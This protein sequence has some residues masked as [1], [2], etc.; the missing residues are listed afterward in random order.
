MKA[1]KPGTDQRVEFYVLVD[2]E[3]VQEYTLPSAD[4]QP[5][6]NTIER[7]IAVKPNQDI[8]VKGLF[9]GTCL[10]SSYDLVVDGSFLT[11]RRVSGNNSGQLIV[12]RRDIDLDDPMDCPL[13]KGWK[14]MKSPTDLYQGKLF[15]Q[16]LSST[17]VN[18]IGK[19]EQ[20][21]QGAAR[22]GVG[23][24][25][26][27]VS[28]NQQGQDQYVDKEWD[29][30]LQG[31][32]NRGQVHVRPSGVTPDHT[33]G[34]HRSKKVGQKQSKRHRDHFEGTR[35]GSGPWARFVFYYRS[36]EALE[37][38]G[39]VPAP[40]EQLALEPHN[41]DFYFAPPMRAK[42]K[43]G[44][45]EAEGKEHP[46]RGQPKGAS[47]T[48]APSARSDASDEEDAEEEDAAVEEG[49]V[50][51]KKSNMRTRSMRDSAS[52]DSDDDMQDDKEI[53][54]SIDAE[55]QPQRVVSSPSR[56]TIAGFSGAPWAFGRPQEA[57]CSSDPVNDSIGSWSFD[58]LDKT[59]VPQSPAQAVPDR[60]QD[61]HEQQVGLTSEPDRRSDSDET[62]G[63][64]TP[65]LSAKR[66]A[67][68]ALSKILGTGLVDDSTRSSAKGKKSG[69]KSSIA[70]QAAATRKASAS[71]FG[72]RNLNSGSST[73]AK[74]EPRAKMDWSCLPSEK[75]IVAFIGEGGRATDSLMSIFPKGEWVDDHLVGN[76]DRAHL[77]KK[78]AK[79]ELYRRV[80]L[81]AEKDPNNETW[82]WLKPEYRQQG[83]GEQVSCP[84]AS[85][86]AVQNDRNEEVGDSNSTTAPSAAATPTPNH[87]RGPSSSMT[88]DTAT[89]KKARTMTP[90]EQLIEATQKL[91]QREAEVAEMKAKLER[92]KA[93]KAQQDEAA[94]RAK[95]AAALREVERV[96][97]D[98]SALE[99]EQAEI[100]AQLAA[101]EGV[102]SDGEEE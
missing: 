78:Q 90:S 1:Q 91:A 10:H 100:A 80:L 70:S 37:K 38:A 18:S 92:K 58:F 14:S 75:D 27:V 9:N 54:Q 71:S 45:L 31:W 2:G 46:K 4:P 20:E 59:D 36:K 101:M 32:R 49:E 87:K 64:S 33:L 26:V 69:N 85:I 25:E 17:D 66:A 96:V 84:P 34:L 68:S 99:Q 48:S 22:P 5:D 12:A 53:H 13:P 62:F 74:E 63:T 42:G 102:G 60:G 76:A 24:I 41:G 81:V 44:R 6:G 57:A 82:T 97:A 7:F 77:A 95:E 29:I 55:D 88:P 52:P 94:K 50:A 30:Q 65:G 86:G 15:V 72:G 40:D 56:E 21:M 67:A 8:E 83:F 35:F 61:E 51:V 19:H 43:K 93:R 89:T 11:A 3:R 47:S 28:M 79:L 98:T 39:C 23:S 16:K 73:K